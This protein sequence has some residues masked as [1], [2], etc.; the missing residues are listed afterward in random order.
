MHLN[1]RI[2]DFSGE[3]GDGPISFEGFK[4]LVPLGQVNPK[5]KGI[6]NLTNNVFR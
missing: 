5:A 4:K 1:C 3:T 6:S 2:S